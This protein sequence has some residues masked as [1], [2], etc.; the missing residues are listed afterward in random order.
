MEY[1][2]EY[3]FLLVVSFRLMPIFR[4]ELPR[5]PAHMGLHCV[6]SFSAVTKLLCLL[7]LD[8]QIFILSTLRAEILRM[9]LANVESTESYF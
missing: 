6:L 3:F 4:L 7:P 8:R 9:L 5:I 1:G 2:S